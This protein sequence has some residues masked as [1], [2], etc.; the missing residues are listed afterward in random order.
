MDLYVFSYMG[1][2]F[3]QFTALSTFVITFFRMG[4][5]VFVKTI[6]DSERLV[7]HSTSKWAITC[8]IA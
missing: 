3:K 5:E 7:A 1:D 8:M 6:L 2:A 4:V